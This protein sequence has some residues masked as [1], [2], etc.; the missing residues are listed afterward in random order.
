ML[1]LEKV[2]RESTVRKELAA[3]EKL[4]TAFARHQIL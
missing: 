3:G 4:A 1:A 2:D